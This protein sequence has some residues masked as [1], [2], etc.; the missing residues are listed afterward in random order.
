MGVF[1]TALLTGEHDVRARGVSLKGGIQNDVSHKT[2]A[3]AIRSLSVCQLPHGHR[4]PWLQ[5]EKRQEENVISFPYF[6]GFH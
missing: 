5:I 4:F 3:R 6:P 2:F 1:G